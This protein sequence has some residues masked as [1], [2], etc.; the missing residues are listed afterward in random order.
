MTVVARKDATSPQWV[1]VPD[2][3]RTAIFP[4]LSF[5]IEQRA[6]DLAVKGVGA[7]T[8]LYG[9]FDQDWA[10]TIGLRTELLDQDSTPII[11]RYVTSEIWLGE[12]PW[13]AQSEINAKDD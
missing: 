12:A 5:E 6:Y 13:G 8:P 2:D 3:N 9:G 7:R 4:D 10:S 11:P 1:A